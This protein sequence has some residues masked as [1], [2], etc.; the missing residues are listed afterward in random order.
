MKRPKCPWGLK[1]LKLTQADSDADTNG[2]V[3]NLTNKLHRQVEKDS[4]TDAG[5]ENGFHCGKWPKYPF[6]WF[7][8]KDWDKMQEKL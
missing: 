7:Y 4:K 5:T 6:V 1:R 2:F 3:Q 8:A